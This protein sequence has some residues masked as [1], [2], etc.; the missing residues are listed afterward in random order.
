MDDAEGVAVRARA[1]KVVNKVARLVV[2]H[3]KKE[4]KR[5]RRDRKG[6]KE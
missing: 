6:L 2:E 1:D 5:S 4:Y 3:K